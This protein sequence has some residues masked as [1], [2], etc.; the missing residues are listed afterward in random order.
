MAVTVW[1]YSLAA[2]TFLARVVVTHNHSGVTETHH[3]SAGHILELR[4]HI[5]DAHTN[6]T[7]S[8]G[9]RNLPPGVEVRDRSLWFL[10]V[11]TSHN[12]TFTCEIRDGRESAREEFGLWVSREECPAPSEMKSFPRGESHSLPCKQ[13]TIFQMNDTRNISW[14]KD[15]HPIQRE[16]EP[17]TVDV[18]GSM[19]LPAASEEDA[20]KYTC[21]V[22]VS[23]NGKT[24]T[25]ARSILLTIKNESTVFVDPEVLA[26]NNEI[27]IAEVG[28]FKHGADVCRLCRLQC[29]QGDIHLL[30]YRRQLHYGLQGVKGVI[31]LVSFSFYN[32]SKGKVYG[33]STLSISKVLHSFL[34]VPIFCN[35]MSPFAQSKGSV[36]LQEADFSSHYN[37]VAL[38][39]AASLAVVGLAAAVFCKTDLMLASRTLLRHFSKPQ[40]PDVKLYDAYVSFL[41]PDSLSS[42]EMAHFALHILPE[43]LEKQHGYSLYIRGRDD[44]PGEAFC[45]IIASTV[46]I[47]HRVII[48][49]S[50]EAKPSSRTEEAGPFH[51][52]QDLFCYEQKLALYNAL[53]QNNLQVI[54]VEID[55][56]V[57]YG[58]LPES[59]RYIKRKQGA[60][61]WRTTFSGTHNLWILH[62]N[63]N[64]WKKLRYHMPSVPTRKC[65]TV[66]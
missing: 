11:Q 58:L 6:I 30:D 20:G 51:D 48:L 31:D 56:P 47:C 17:I 57:D 2:L 40:A 50:A 32:V 9:G 35:V 7:W 19:R 5:A 1:I 45:D 63:R 43:E 3:V 66:V 25:S 23:V 8:R 26:P 4:C 10:P 44:C 22:D 33:V 14:L 39:L 38:C 24:Y 55:G 21:L 49:L 16:G 54:L 59:L 42:V 29:G 36:L 52:D 64:F 34:N 18:R 15:C 62:S 27:H 46:Q 12:G 65:Q 37:S 13:K 60:L 53:T 28:K 61:K 41:H